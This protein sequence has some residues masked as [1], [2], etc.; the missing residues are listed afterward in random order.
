MTGLS[1]GMTFSLCR[2]LHQW[3]FEG[4]LFDP[5]GEF[6]IQMSEQYLEFRGVNYQ[7]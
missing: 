7:I 6:M 4:I 2:F 3:L 1:R 5:Y